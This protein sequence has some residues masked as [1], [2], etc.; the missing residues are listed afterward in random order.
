MLLWVM[1]TGVRIARGS[2]DERWFMSRA[3][4]GC[5]ILRLQGYDQLY[6]LVR[7]FLWV[8]NYILVAKAQSLDIA[9]RN[10]SSTGPENIEYQI[11]MP[12]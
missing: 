11:C 12:R 4:Q 8:E 6:A 3:V 2:D 10:P 7:N 5:R 9:E 1:I